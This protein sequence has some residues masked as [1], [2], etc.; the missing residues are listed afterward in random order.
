[1]RH[2]VFSLHEEDANPLI[3]AVLHERMDLMTCLSER[4]DTE[5]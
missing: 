5:Q 1:M 4:L 2:H 3:I